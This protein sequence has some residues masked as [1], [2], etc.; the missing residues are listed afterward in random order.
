M[1]AVG[2]VYNHSMQVIICI[3]HGYCLAQGNIKRHLR[4]IHRTKG[5]TLKTACSKIADL[6]LADLSTLE[7]PFGSLPIPY[8]TVENG[9]QCAVTAC[10]LDSRALSKSR[11]TVEKHL[12]EVHN[13]GRRPG[14]T[15]PQGTDIRQV[16]MQSLL[17]SYQRKLFVVQGSSSLDIRPREC[18]P[19][20]SHATSEE[21]HPSTDMQAL[22]SLLEAQYTVSKQDWQQIHDRLPLPD[23]Q[24]HDLGAPWLNR[25]GISRWVAGFEMDKKELRECMEPLPCSKGSSF[26]IHTALY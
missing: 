25:T 24:D 9:Y 19:D 13:I 15:P 4:V 2:L 6:L 11:S 5:S 12:S 17:P 18:Q 26:P 8:L 16:C 10:N 3:E 14:K 7:V 22:S 1:E 23:T 20:V 21:A